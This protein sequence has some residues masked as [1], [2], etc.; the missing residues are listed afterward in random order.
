MVS[1]LVAHVLEANEDTEAQQLEDVRDD[2]IQLHHVGVR[3]GAVGVV[4]VVRVEVLLLV[5]SDNLEA[6]VR[7]L[8]LGEQ[9]VQ[10]EHQVFERN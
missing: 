5:L 9:P 6:P 8:E 7:L 2:V 10:H 4:A 1:V 3:V